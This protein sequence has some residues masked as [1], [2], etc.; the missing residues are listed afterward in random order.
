MSVPP[1]IGFFDSGI[2]GLSVLRHAPARLGRAEYLYVADSAYAPYGGKPIALVR[3]RSLAIAR[4]LADHGVDAIVIA[5]NTA[6]AI[7]AEVI[8]AE[9]HLPV[10][11]MEPAIKPAMLDSASKIVAVLATASTLGSDRYHSLKQRHAAGGTVIE[12]ACHHWVEAVEDGALDDPATARRVVEDLREIRQL[13]ADTYILG[14]THFPFLRA[15]IEI[16]LQG[17]GRIVDPAPAVIEQL[18]RRLA[19]SPAVS[20]DTRSTPLL[21]VFSSGDPDLV[22]ARIGQLLGW[23]APAQSLCL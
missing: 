20:P 15:H 8:R 14:C 17:E 3:E 11:A 4:F 7:A 16:A 21:T 1:R 2:G 10:V 19:I 9:L 6:T 18:A 23:Q 5:C 12:R 22:Q 13:G